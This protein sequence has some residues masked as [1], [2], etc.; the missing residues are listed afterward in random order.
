[1]GKV[2]LER[3]LCK[4]DKASCLAV[5]F[6]LD[7]LCREAKVRKGQ[8]KGTYGLGKGNRRTFQ[9]FTARWRNKERSNRRSLARKNLPADE[10][11]ASHLNISAHSK[12]LLLEQIR[13]VEKTAVI[14]EKT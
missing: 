6:S 12:V 8:E 3:K 7:K 1:L 2:P 13:C 4:Q 11:L 5:C 9:A 14:V 10:K